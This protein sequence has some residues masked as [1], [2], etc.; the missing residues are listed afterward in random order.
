VQD[1]LHNLAEAVQDERSFLEFLRALEADR[2]DEVAKERATP[3]P[4]YMQG[5]NGW[6][7]GTIEAFLDAAI[8]WAD[9]SFDGMEFYEEP[10]NPWKRCTEILLMGKEYE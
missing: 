9:D 8:R 4:P 2:S 10:S 5:A 7:N 6:E 3:S 1:E